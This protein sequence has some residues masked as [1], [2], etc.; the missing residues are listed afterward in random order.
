MIDAEEMETLLRN[1]QSADKLS[2]D[3]ILS[4]IH[5][6]FGPDATAFPIEVV[7]QRCLTHIQ[8]KY[9]AKKRTP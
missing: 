3:E 1:I 4:I 8:E 6:E 5:D 7:V 2:R 9:D